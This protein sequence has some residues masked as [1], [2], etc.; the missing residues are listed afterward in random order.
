MANGI[1]IIVIMSIVSSIGVRMKYITQSPKHLNGYL[2]SLLAVFTKYFFQKSST[3]IASIQESS[4]RIFREI[5]KAQS[6][7][8]SSIKSFQRSFMYTA[9]ASQ[10]SIFHFSVQ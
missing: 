8:S 3:Y 9:L 1:H 7:K 5:L 6:S 2:S 10:K 4:M